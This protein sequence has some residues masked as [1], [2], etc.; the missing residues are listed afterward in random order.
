MRPR[1]WRRASS[2]ATALLLGLLL[3]LLLRLHVKQLQHACDARRQRAEHEQQR[4]RA[5]ACAVGTAG[6]LFEQVMPDGLVASASRSHHAQ[7]ITR[8]SRN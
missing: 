3:L 1:W 7:L 8:C 4:P 5:Q 2:S 6:W